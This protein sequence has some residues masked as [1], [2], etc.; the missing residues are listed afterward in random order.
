MGLSILVVDANP[1]FRRVLGDVL[2]G[3][4][5]VDAVAHAASAAE[6]RRLAAARRPDVA[7]VD[8]SLAAGAGPDLVGRLRHE[9]PRVT[10]IG[11]AERNAGPGPAGLARFRGASAIVTRPAPGPFRRVVTELSTRFAPLIAAAGRAHGRAAPAGGGGPAGQRAPQGP[12]WITVI[13][14][15]TG[16]PEALGRVVPLLP[17]DY[18]TPIVVVQHMPPDFTRALAESLDARAC[19]AV[20]EGRDG[21]VLA[22][23]DVVVAPGGRHLEV[24]GSAARP[25]VVLHDGP[26]ELGVRPSANVLLRSLAAVDGSRRVLTVVMTGMGEDGLAGLRALRP[27]RPYCL[28]QTEASCAVYGMP[29]AVELAGLADEAVPLERLAA[30]LAAVARGTVPLP[31]S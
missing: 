15:S 6:A 10:V 12:F 9:D 3:L 11:V 17:A 14:V 21:E 28:T 2:A 27:R 25:R 4:P 5:G 31:T 19:L 7:V 20:R 26:P 13:A 24:G 8:L 16:G 22:A 23:G 30:R 18:P 1:V 29:R